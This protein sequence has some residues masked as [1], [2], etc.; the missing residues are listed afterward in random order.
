MSPGEI[1]LGI[2]IGGTKTNIGLVDTKGT[3]LAQRR[4]P[5][6]TNA[7]CQSAEQDLQSIIQGTQ[8]L[9]TELNSKPTIRSIGIGVPGTVDRS[10][11]EVVF[12][13][14]LNWRHVPIRDFFAK[15]FDLPICVGQD[16]EAAAWGEFLFGAGRDMRDI[17]CITIG[18]GI[19]CGLVIG[20][21]LYKGR[22]GTA[23]EIGHTMVEKAGLACNCGRSGCAEAY[24]SG[25]AILK[26]F[27][28]A[29]QAGQKSSLLQHMELD[30]ITTRDIFSGAKA[31][32]LL[33]EAVIKDAV[34]YLSMALTNLV[35]LMCPEAVILSGGIS[36][37]RELFVNPLIEQTYARMYSVLV[38]KVKI[39]T[40]EL[41]TNAP[42]IGAAMLCKDP[43]YQGSMGK[44]GKS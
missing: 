24:A 12:A 41:G 17:A 3:V 28:E 36:Q 4:I 18:T 2:D 7:H 35:N 37:Q 30:K 15:T 32:D 20:G 9:I 23:G 1:Y 16:T 40:A 13:P 34:E 14:N 38:D 26:R 29:V 43:S 21:Q 27:R 6:S 31:H 5:T 8:E 42:L 10:L 19:G 39:T 22:F 11:G 33:S 44:E 25:T